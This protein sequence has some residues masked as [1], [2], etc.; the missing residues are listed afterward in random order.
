MMWIKLT[1][2]ESTRSF[3]KT[4]YKKMSLEHLNLTKMS[5]RSPASMLVLKFLKT[6]TFLG[7]LL[8]LQK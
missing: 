4:F 5:R 3:Y 2:G 1:M 8:K 7:A 6:V